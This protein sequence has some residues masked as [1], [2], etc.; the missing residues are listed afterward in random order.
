MKIWQYDTKS[1][2]RAMS[3]DSKQIRKDPLD[4]GVNSKKPGDPVL[5][6]KDKRVPN[7]DATQ[8]FDSVAKL[9]HSLIKD[10]KSVPQLTKRPKP[11]SNNLKLDDLGN[12][13][14]KY[15]VVTKDELLRKPTN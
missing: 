3:L 2:T 14:R 9:C 15:T 12:S 10:L 8:H 11:T 4:M 5:V 13:E 7:Y 6:H 1:K